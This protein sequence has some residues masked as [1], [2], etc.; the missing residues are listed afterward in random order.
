MTFLLD[1][2]IFIEAKQRYY[3]FDICPGFWQALV[4]QYGRGRLL[5]IDRVKTELTDNFDDDDELKKWVLTTMPHACFLSTDQE[6]VLDAYRDA[7]GWVMAQPQFTPAAKA[8]FA[9]VDNAD[10]WVIAVARAVDATIVTHEKPNPNKRN[11]VPIP[12]VCVALGIP[13]VDT[14]GM[15]R[16]LATR[17]SWHEP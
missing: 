8:E 9:S 10:A 16:A 2:N 7:V 3:A 11:K 6:A 5:S 14:F 1:S 13:Y 4:W 15:L 17:F 12:N